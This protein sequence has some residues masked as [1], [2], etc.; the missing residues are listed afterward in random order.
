[1][2]ILAVVLTVCVGIVTC[3]SAREVQIT[4]YNDD[5]GLVRDVRDVDLSAGAGSLSVTDVAARIDPTSVHLVSLTRESGITVLEQNYRYD[6]ASPDRILERYLDSQVQAV[7]EGGELHEGKLLS[8]TGDQL[9]LM[10]D[11]GLSILQRDKIVDVRCSALPSGLI[12]RPTLVWTVDADRAG[13]QKAELSYLTGGISW[14]AEYVAVVNDSDTEADLAGWV[15]VDNQSGATYPDAKLQLIAGDVNR[16]QPSPPARPMLAMEG[17]RMKADVGFEEE[18]FFEYHLYTLPRA[19]TIS[20]RETKQIALFPPAHTP[21]VKLY[22]Y[23]PW[24][25]EQKIRTVLQFENREERGLGMPLPKGK[26]RTYK[27]DSK[28]GQQFIGE[29]WIDHTPK[30][31]K[32]RLFL[33]NAFDVVAERT[34]KDQNR[35]SDRVW[36]QT[37][38]VKFRNHKKEKVTIVAG[39]RFWGDWQVVTSTVPARKK[40]A[41][42]AEWSVD[43]AP[44]A[45]TVLAYTIRTTR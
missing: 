16:V 8:F 35:I 42:T 40:D 30:D 33:G 23:R 29:D 9:V 36:E 22:E 12:T 3:A 21:V 41:T 28:G 20:D 15:S 26:V 11:K 2:R 31:E 5:L 17:A 1:M 24:E 34:V 32:V 19:T 38:E 27:R 14:H 4:V 18:S 10:G 44:D 43:V 6:L 7:L 45:E 25:N 13:T 39:D 37:V